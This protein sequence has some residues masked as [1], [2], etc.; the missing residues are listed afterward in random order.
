MNFKT[1]L[2]LLVLLA[3]VGTFF[4]WDKD[5]PSVDVDAPLVD[6]TKQ[7]L[8]SV[9]SF[10]K[11]KIAS[12]SIEKNGKTVTLEKQGTEW[13]QTQPVTF[14][15]NSWSAGQPGEN[16]LGLTYTE[17]LTPGKNGAPSLVE[18]KLD[19]PLAVIT[20]KFNDDTPPQTFKLGRRGIGGRGYLMLN[21]DASLYVVND[22]L[23]KSILDDD[24]A[25]WRNKSLK[26]P[27]EGQIN[28]LTKI[29][30]HGALQVVKA[31]GNWVF[32][33][34][35]TGRVSRETVT[36][37]LGAI[38]GIYISRFVA[39]K[40]ADISAYGLD[41][42]LVKVVLQLPAIASEKSDD[43]DKATQTAAQPRYQTFVIGAPVDL[44]NERYFATFADGQEVGDV[45]FEIS[46]TDYEKFE[47][48][49]NSLRD[50]SLTP[51][52]SSDV[53]KIVLTQNDQVAVQLLKSANGWGY[54]DPK[55][56][57]GLDQ[58]LAEQLLGKI[59]DAKA[60]SYVVNPKLIDKALLVVTLGATGRASDEELKFFANG[61][62]NVTVQRNNEAVG[63][64]VPRSQLEMVLGTSVAMLRNRTIKDWSP[65]DL[66]VVDITLP[67]KANTMLHFSRSDAAWKLDGYDKHESFAWGE[68]LDA[69]A[70]L[71]VDSWQTPGPIGDKVYTI[72]CGNDEMTLTLKVD[73]DTRVASL[74]ELSLD[75]MV[76]EAFVDKLTAELRPRTIVD[77]TRDA[78]QKCRSRPRNRTSLSITRMANLLL[79]VSSLMSRKSEHS[80]IRLEVY[81]LSV[82]FRQ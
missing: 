11:D 12:L 27:T 82:T 67:E 17:K 58:E 3:I 65:T 14:K 13:Q 55:P 63:Y 33:G 73:P 50:A 10:D 30:T 64:V 1:T 56:G 70:P 40:P 80:S 38:N 49:I 39:D 23:H 37:L 47:K 19:T 22:D 16:A 6:Q 69:L 45:V 62:D 25:D 71:K 75:F 31:E 21:D 32:A 54:G 77:V 46:K 24:I 34:D 79:K 57:Y 4:L 5:N 7:P 76:S 8:L 42:P 61:S 2:F 68:L 18:V 51:V 35:H 9:D 28:Q 52:V 72:T 59:T 26:A 60:Q 20:I 78:I 53:T 36:E 81:V 43:K 66:K 15:L 48:D 41:K 74:D 29:D 44:K